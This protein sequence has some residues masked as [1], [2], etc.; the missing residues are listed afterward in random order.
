MQMKSA[1]LKR[2]P[3][4]LVIWYERW[5]SLF[6]IIYVPLQF[7]KQLVT[8]YETTKLKCPWMQL[9]ENEGAENEKKAKEDTSDLNT[10]TEEELKALVCTY[11]C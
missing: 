2:L 9:E 5:F 8:D 1:K 10:A 4:I 6:D 11:V 7:G 3:N